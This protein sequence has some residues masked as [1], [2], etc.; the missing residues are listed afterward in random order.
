MMK[1]LQFLSLFGALL[2]LSGCPASSCADLVPPSTSSQDKN[3]IIVSEQVRLQVS[4]QKLASCEPTDEVPTPESLT[5]EISGPDNLPVDSQSS[6]GSPTTDDATIRFTPTKQGRYHVFAAFDPVGGIQQFDLYAALNRSAEAPLQMLPENCN[7]LERTKRGGFLC[8]TD[9]VRDGAVVQRFPNARMAAAGDAVWAVSPTQIMRLADTGTTLELLA[10]RTNSVGQAIFLL[11][12]ADELVIMYGSALERITFDGTQLTS[13]G[14][15]TWVPSTQPI[16]PPSLQAVLLRTG[17]Q[18]ATVVGGGSTTFGTTV[19]QVCPYQMQQ[20]R[21]VRTSAN[22]QLLATE[23]VGFEP[24]ALW[25]GNGAGVL[26]NFTDVHRME[27]TG[28]ALV[29][30]ASLP[31]GNSFQ[32]IIHT[33]ELRNTAI[34]VITPFI[35]SIGTRSRATVPVYTPDRGIL[36]EMLDADVPEPT[37]TTTLLWGNTN[38]NS[39]TLH[40]RTRPSTP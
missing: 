32:L 3:V 36:L 26:D 22:C 17:D 12:S 28:T 24:N 7:A 21:F 5:V 25:I 23:V 29:D 8:D 37:A 9:F 39:G 38:P 16:H 10:S 4:P 13:T 40:V 6:L 27:W 30:Q 20:G 11:A 33:P 34:P 18:L 14:L 15:T 2:G 31:L 35:P 19:I 1:I